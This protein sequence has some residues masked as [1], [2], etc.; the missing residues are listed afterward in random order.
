MASATSITLFFFLIVIGLILIIF[1]GDTFVKSVSWI[2]EKLGVPRF[3]IGATLVSFVTTLPEI[4][5]SSIAASQG[6]VDIA[7]GN[8]VG[9][10]NANIALIMAL[11][12]LFI[13][14]A[15]KRREYVTKFLLLLVA[16]LSLWLI[17]FTK[18]ELSLYYSLIPI[19]IFVIFIIENIF[20]LPGI[21]RLCVQAIFGRDYPII[22]AYVLIMGVLFVVCNLI[23]DVVSCYIDPRIAEKEV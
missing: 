21:G 7:I 12:I 8:A 10:V 2:A 9:S 20:V 3:I 16:I 17:V 11:S 1:G 14:M 13:P 5:V 22:Q 23:V 4:I 19:G 15:V 6:K 18:K